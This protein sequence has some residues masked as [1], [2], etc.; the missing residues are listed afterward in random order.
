MRRIALIVAIFILLVG[1]TFSE[2][3]KTET[4]EKEHLPTLMLENASYTI[5]QRGQRPIKLEG[6]KVTFYADDNN[7]LLEDFSF[8]QLDENGEVELHGSA[9]KGIMNTSTNVIKLDGD[10]HLLQVES[11]MEIKAEYIVFDADN[12]EISADGL[13]MIKSKD[14]EF[15]GIGFKGDLRE[16]RYTFDNLEKGK[17][18]N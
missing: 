6:A 17:I 7:A 16:Q 1:C 18:G 11:E 14:G 12:E 5:G 2:E 4:H 9:R 13:V 3:T 8:Y 15:A 10:V